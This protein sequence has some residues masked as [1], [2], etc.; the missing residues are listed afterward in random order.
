MGF[1]QGL[2]GQSFQANSHPNS[3]EVPSLEEWVHLRR[4]VPSSALTSHIY[5]ILTLPVPKEAE[6]RRTVTMVA[7]INDNN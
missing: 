5:S 2:L 7:A 3:L 1:V 4:A 6:R